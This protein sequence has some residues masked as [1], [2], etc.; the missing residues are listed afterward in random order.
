MA[1]KAEERARLRELLIQRKGVMT[2]Y[3]NKAQRVIA[4]KNTTRLRECMF[5]LIET[6][7]ALEGLFYDFT[8]MLES[9]DAVINDA[10][11]QDISQ[12]Y[13]TDLNTCHDFFFC[14]FH[15]PHL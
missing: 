9:P 7:D 15:E 14:Q 8:S 5:S 1:G 6:M 2:R 12:K 4:E 11:F 10:W 3:S 13:I